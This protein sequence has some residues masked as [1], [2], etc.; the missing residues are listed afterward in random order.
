MDGKTAVVIGAGVAGCCASALLAANGVKVI[1]VEKKPYVGGR[2]ATRSPGEWG[3]TDEPWSEYGV[4]FGHHVFGANGFLER[5]VDETGARA[6]IDLHKLPMAYFLRNGQLNQAPATF[7]ESLGAYNYVGIREK[8]KLF[9]FNKFA[10]KIPTR[11]AMEKYGRVPLRQ[12]VERF[13]LGPQAA[14]I[15][16]EGFAA[17]YQTTVDLDKNS[18]GDLILCMKLLQRG[19]EK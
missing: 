19:F 6:K 11:E 7:W 8:L 13:R 3:W 15:I 16:V 10:Q 1:L 4:D 9:R 18:A 14:E 2:A 17:G 12:L 5:V